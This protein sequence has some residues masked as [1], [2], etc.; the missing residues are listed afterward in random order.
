MNVRRALYIA[1]AA[2]AALLGTAT[3]ASAAY[4]T[5]FFDAC[6]PVTDCNPSASGDIT[7]Y[8]R[9][10][11]VDGGIYNYSGQHGWAVLTA[12]KGSTKVNTLITEVDVNDYAVIEGNLGDTNLVG[13]IDRIKVAICVGPTVDNLTCGTIV[14]SYKPS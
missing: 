1:A 8:N 4:P 7:W 3:P 5:T 11:Y 12:Y 9:T 2:G 6:G 10:A 14:N 13:G